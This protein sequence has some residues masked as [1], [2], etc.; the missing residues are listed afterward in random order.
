MTMA[1]VSI[2]TCDRVASGIAFVLRG[3]SVT[4]LPNKSEAT[5]AEASLNKSPRDFGSVVVA[6][7]A[8]VAKLFRACRIIHIAI[9]A[10]VA[11]GA[12]EASRASANATSDKSSSHRDRVAV[13]I[14]VR[15]A[16]NFGAAWIVFV[17]CG[18]QVAGI[19]Y[20]TS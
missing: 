6:V 1:I 10:R 4:P 20:K 3:A 8:V 14:S 17:I 15:S 9:R 7:C 16:W 11:I 18:T 2:G 13:A 12:S 5:R 19:T